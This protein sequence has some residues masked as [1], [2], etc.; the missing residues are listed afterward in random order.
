[1]S[2]ISKDV[3][4]VSGFPAFQ[5][6][7]RFL[8]PK[9]RF[10]SYP[11][12]TGIIEATEPENGGLVSGYMVQGPG[13]DYPAQSSS[14]RRYPEFNIPDSEAYFDPIQGLP[15][16]GV[17]RQVRDEGDDLNKV[18]GESTKVQR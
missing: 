4:D 1:M 16:R 14:D 6:R 12:G 15:P 13:A 3:P 8:T 2:K 11:A 18:G 9:E 10:K 5:G 17:I 7:A